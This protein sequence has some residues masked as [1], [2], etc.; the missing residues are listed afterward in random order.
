MST[1]GNKI[2]SKYYEKGT[3][4]IPLEYVARIS[5]TEELGARLKR[6]RGKTSRRALAEKLTAANYDYS[7]QYLQKIEDGRALTVPLDLVLAI[8]EILEIRLGQIL[9][10]ANLD[11]PEEFTTGG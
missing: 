9:P 1:T 10:V 6:L 7:H 2:L 5:W 8:C 4:M 11:Y 3:P